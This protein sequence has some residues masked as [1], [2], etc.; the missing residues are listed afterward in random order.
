MPKIALLKRPCKLCKDV[1]SK[2]DVPDLICGHFICP[3]CYCKLKKENINYC[4]CC[5]K[6]LE[7]KF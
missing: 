7:R 4:I 2:Q 3:S 5:D 1:V 6:T